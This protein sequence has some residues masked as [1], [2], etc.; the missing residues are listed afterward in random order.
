MHNRGL[1]RTECVTLIVTL[2]LLAVVITACTSKAAAA[3]AKDSPAAR[4]ACAE[5]L[6][7]IAQSMVIYAADN[8]DM[9][10]TLS[11]PKSATAYNPALSPDEG[12]ASA[13]DTIK[14]IYTEN[15]NTD[16]PHA[17]LW[18]LVL[19][20]D[21]QRPDTKAFICPADPFAETPAELKS[22]SGNYYRNFQSPQ[23]ISYSIAH[24]WMQGYEGKP[25]MGGHWRNT[26]NV[27][28]VILSDMAPYQ[29]A[30]GAVDEVSK[31]GNS[32]NHNGQGQNVAYAD[33]HSDWAR[34]S[35]IGE[36]GDDIFRVS[37]KPGTANPDEQPLDAGKLPAAIKSSM[38]PFDVVM[39][40][41]RSEKGELK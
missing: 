1:T 25:S 11:P 16:N 6:R 5:N 38:E 14:S 7:K 28:V 37:L 32:V 26:S 19:R 15:L 23:N 22:G 2:F 36:N 29:S 24:P 20:Y 18:L 41:M 9:Y 34:S 21:G 33:G 35:K 4:Q 8:A 12:Q 27:G 39:V 10:P 31:T 40:P 30:S 13:E 17:P 3:K